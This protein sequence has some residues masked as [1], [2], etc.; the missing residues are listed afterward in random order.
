MLTICIDSK[1][2]QVYNIVTTK[3]RISFGLHAFYLQHD[4]NYNAAG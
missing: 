3:A 4:N 2:N 1:A